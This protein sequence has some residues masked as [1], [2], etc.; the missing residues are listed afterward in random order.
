MPKVSEPLFCTPIGSPPMRGVVGTPL[1]SLRILPNS[2][3]FMS[4]PAGPW[5]D[6]DPGTSQMPLIAALCVMLKSETARL[7]WGANQN[8]LVMELEKASPAMVAE[9]LSID[10]L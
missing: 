2:H 3:P 8:Q 4:A 5:R 10:L 1:F 9:S 7:I 6:L